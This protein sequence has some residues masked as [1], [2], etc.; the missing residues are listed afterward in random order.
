MGRYKLTIEYDGSP[1]V[2]W[3]R[4][5]NGLSVQQVLETAIFSFCQQNVTVH[6]ASR[7]DAGVHALRQIAHVDLLKD[8][9]PEQIRDATNAYLRPHPISILDVEAVNDNFHARFSALSRHYVYRIINR[10]ARLTLDTGHAWWIR[11]PLDVEVMQASVSCLLGRHDFSTFRSS[12]CQAKSPIRTVD[13]TL[14]TRK[15]DVVTVAISAKSFLHHQVCNIV[16]TLYLIGAGRWSVTDLRQALE[17]RDRRAGGPAA[18]ACGLYLTEVR[19]LRKTEP[20]A[21]NIL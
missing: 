4:Q 9:M 7:T 2:G 21:N 3:Q 1:F 10:R 18:P 5:V 17:A 20:A 11:K 13:T 16:G 15:D 12:K 19:Y 14:I 6:G 8:Y